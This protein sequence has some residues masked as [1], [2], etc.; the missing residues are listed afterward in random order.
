MNEAN[1]TF[2]DESSLAGTTRFSAPGN[3]DTRYGERPVAELPWWA[4]RSEHDPRDRGD[5]L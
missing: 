5:R 2:S 1:E 4:I 3:R